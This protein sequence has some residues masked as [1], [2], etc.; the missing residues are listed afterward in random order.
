MKESMVTARSV[1]A[2]YPISLVQ[3]GWN[4]VKTTFVVCAW[5]IILGSI[6]DKSKDTAGDGN[7]R[8]EQRDKMYLFCLYGLFQSMF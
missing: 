5:L 1:A 8:L 6:C 3:S 7:N 2:E 4:Q